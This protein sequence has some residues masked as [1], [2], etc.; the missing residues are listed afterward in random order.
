MSSVLLSLVVIRAV[1]I[2]RA[3]HFYERL[4]LQFDKQRHGNGPEHYST[5]LGT[6]LFEIYPYKNGA[7]TTAGVRLG[8]IVKSLSELMERL[9]TLEIK[10]ISPLQN[11][12]SGSFAVVE[13]FDGHKVELSEARL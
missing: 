6:T 12:E 3:V 8:F 7:K 2:D 9:K 4:G 1:D 10:I 13:D 11:N 5:N